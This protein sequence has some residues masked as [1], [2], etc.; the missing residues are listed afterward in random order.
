MLISYAR[1][2]TH[3][4]SPKFWSLYH[5]LPF[6]VR[7]LADKNYLLLKDNPFHPSL[8][9]KRV[10]RV[11]RRWSV[12]VGEHYRALGT[13]VPEGF[14]WVWIGTHAEYDSLLR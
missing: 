8:H 13:E 2:V 11:T 12:R 3:S 9:F 10:D 5:S 1:D 4:T 7:S 14:L 6:E